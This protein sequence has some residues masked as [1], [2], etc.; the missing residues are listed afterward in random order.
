MPN[1]TLV[2]EKNSLITKDNKK[3]ATKQNISTATRVSLLRNDD[4][5]ILPPINLYRPK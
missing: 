3:T 5:I 4:F 2:E 1:F